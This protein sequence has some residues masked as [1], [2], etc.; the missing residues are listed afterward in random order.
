MRHPREGG[1][2]LKALRNMDS[3]LHGNDDRMMKRDFETGSHILAD[4]FYLREVECNLI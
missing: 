3:R 4:I 1:G 2:S